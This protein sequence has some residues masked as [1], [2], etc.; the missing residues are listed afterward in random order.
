MVSET[1]AETVNETPA[2]VKTEVDIENHTDAV[3][4]SDSEKK[5][6]PEKKCEEPEVTDNRT[7]EEA[8]KDNVSF[9]VTS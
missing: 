3:E 8:T 9:S 4:E 5:D 2:V 1:V 6:L 7:A